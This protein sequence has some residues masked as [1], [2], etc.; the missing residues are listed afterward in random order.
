MKEFSKFEK[1][2]AKNISNEYHWMIR[3]NKGKLVISENKPYYDK[4]TCQWIYS[5]KTSRLPLDELFSEIKLDDKEVINITDIYNPE[6]LTKEE[7]EYLEGVI[8]PWRCQVSGFV[9]K[10]DT[11]DD[12]EYLQLHFMDYNDTFRN[13]INFPCFERD[14]M[15]KGMCLDEMYSVKDL[16]LFEEF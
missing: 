7:K 10:L 14:T 12:V 1:D 11:T 9:K 4:T 6:I 2:I 3:N 5:G 13:F 15:H 8:G 16:G